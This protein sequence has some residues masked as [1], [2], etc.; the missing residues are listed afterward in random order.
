M[1]KV[2]LNI[3]KLFST[4]F[5]LMWCVG[6]QDDFLEKTPDGKYTGESFYTS[7][8]AV[9]K[10][11][12]P[13]Y[14]RAWFNYNRRSILGLGSLRANDGWNLYMNAEFA[15]FQITALTG[16]IMQAWSSLHTVVTMSNAILHDVSK[17]S[18]PDVSAEVKN[19][20]IGEAYLMRGVAY[21]Y[22][23]R[24]W[25]AC[26]LFENNDEVVL[27]PVR[28]LNPE[29]D[30]LKF[31]IRDFRCAA[32]YLPVKGINGHASSYAA[33]ALLAKALLAQSGW[34]K[35][36]TRDETILKECIALCEDVIDN[37][38]ATLI[39][40]ENLFKY[41]YNDNDETLLAMKWASPIT[42]SWG[43]CN[44]LLSDLSFS[45]VCDV[46]CWGGSWVASADM[47]ELYNQE[48]QDKKRLKATFF[49]Y[50]TH[51]DY[52]KSASGGYTYDKKWIQLKKG[53]VGSKEDVDG[54]LSVMAS[55]LNTYIIRLADVYLTH[56]EASLGN[57]PALNG[58]RGLESFNAVRSRAGIPHKT[59]ITFEDIIRERRV[60]FCM[61]Y[62]NWYDMVSW[63]RYK[64]EYMLDYFNHQ[65]HR[66]AFID[67]NNVE[68]NP[69][70]S[71]RYNF[72]WRDSN[73]YV[74]WSDALRDDD[75]NIVRSKAD[76]YVFDLETLMRE[77]N[78][79]R[80]VVNESNVFAPYPEADVLQNPYLSM[81]PVPYDFSNNQQN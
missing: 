76:G 52:I 38:G 60:E 72:G 50:D 41:Q 22:M 58:G 32:E 59:A 75:G 42:G 23:L 43:E 48:L 7:D 53:V 69:D 26:I 68:I 40:Y 3:F 65:Q 70:G 20:A 13:L 4:V 29:E 10:A 45:D 34:N 49:T 33:K 62:C 19:Q 39:D 55:P 27:N 12:E 67:N 17:N 61:E 5:C 79:D 44:A 15:R 80:I 6:C 9:L 37:S 21:F 57:K 51:Y 16:E 24:I 78:I 71:I 63:Y 46:N 56:A 31:V 2:T 73:G 74:Y 28:P 14:N 36:G 25:G 66:N 11:C 81:E 64:P 35:G 30:V 54:Q 8:D 18:G 47:I 77:N 1:K